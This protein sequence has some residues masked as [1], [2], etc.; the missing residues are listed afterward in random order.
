MR[1]SEAVT[2]RSGVVWHLAATIGVYLLLAFACAKL[3]LRLARQ[4]RDDAA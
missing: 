3:L 4:P 2:T 1:T